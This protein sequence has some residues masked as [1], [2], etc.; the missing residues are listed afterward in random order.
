MA[1]LAMMS[2]QVGLLRSEGTVHTRDI[3]QVVVEAFGQNLSSAS[4]HI[5]TV[6]GGRRDIEFV[7]GTV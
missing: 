5:R 4:N 2:D 7:Y 3:A 6:A 1:C